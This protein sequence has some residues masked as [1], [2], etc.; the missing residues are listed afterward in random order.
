MFDLTETYQVLVRRALKHAGD[1]GGLDRVADRGARAVRL[2]VADRRRVD[3]ADPARPAHHRA[4]GL[5]AGH[6][7]PGGAPVVVHRGTPDDRVDA[8]AVALRRR[9]RLEHDHA[10]PFAA[11]VPVRSLVKRLAPGVGREEPPLGHHDGRDRVDHHVD[12]PRHRE[13][14]LT[15]P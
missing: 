5:G 1:R 6:R 14:A 15:A 10:D 4:L 9:Q 2:E 8:V 3:S 7:R 13:L 11:D 12:A